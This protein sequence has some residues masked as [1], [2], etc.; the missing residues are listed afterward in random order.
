MMFDAERVQASHTDDAIL[1]TQ[2][3]FRCMQQIIKLSLK[4]KL[5]SEFISR[6]QQ[7]TV[8]NIN[9]SKQS[10]ECQGQLIKNSDL[11]L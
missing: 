6:T 10:G 9:A 5:S 2:S 3:L 4:Y 1:M 11:G 7:N 8:S